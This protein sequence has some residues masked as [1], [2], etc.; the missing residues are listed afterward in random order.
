[1]ILN[2]FFN[3]KSRRSRILEAESGENHR[4]SPPSRSAVARVG[5]GRRQGGTQ[6]VG[7][8]DGVALAGIIG[9]MDGQRR[10][11]RTDIVAQVRLRHGILR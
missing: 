7:I 8:G 2:I 5:L 6:V 9:A 10:Y 3:K 4:D 11:G 1:M